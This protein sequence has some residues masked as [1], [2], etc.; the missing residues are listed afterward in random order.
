MQTHFKAIL[1]CE[2]LNASPFHTA[3]VDATTHSKAILQCFDLQTAGSCVNLNREGQTPLYSHTRAVVDSSTFL[4]MLKNPLGTYRLRDSST[5]SSEI[6]CRLTSRALGGKCRAMQTPSIQ[7]R[8]MPS[9]CWHPISRL[10]CIAS[11]PMQ[12]PLYS[13]S[14]CHVPVHT[15]FQGYIALFL[16]SNSKRLHKPEQGRAIPSVQP[17]TS[18]RGERDVSI[19]AQKPLRYL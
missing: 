16:L 19:Y 12:A 1:H 3:Q 13:P 2:R 7:L 15:P 17:H 6:S 9:P 18:S 14:R 10:H 5:Q 11:S 4:Y 8:L